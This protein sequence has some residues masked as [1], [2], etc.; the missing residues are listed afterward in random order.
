MTSPAAITLCDSLLNCR[1]ATTPVTMGEGTPGEHPPLVSSSSR[2]TYSLKFKKNKNISFK[3][4]GDNGKSASLPLS[5]HQTVKLA[6]L[7]DGDETWLGLLR[8]HT[9]LPPIRELSR[10]DELHTDVIVT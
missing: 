7:V 4:S 10:A 9:V 2:H 3:V 8:T 5:A 1:S 6:Q